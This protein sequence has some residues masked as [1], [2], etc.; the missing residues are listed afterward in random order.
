MNLPIEVL[1]AYKWRKDM[2]ERQLINAITN[3]TVNKTIDRLVESEDRHYDYM[4]GGSQHLM[5]HSM[6]QDVIIKDS[7]THRAITLIHNTTKQF[8]LSWRI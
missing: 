4:I 2:Y 3:G 5:S 7:E 8:L 1:Q 6:F